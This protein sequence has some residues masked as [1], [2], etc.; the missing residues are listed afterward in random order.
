VTLTVL[1]LFAGIGGFSLGLHQ[2]GLYTTKAFCEWDPVCQKVLK[3]NFPGIPVYGDIDELVKSPTEHCDVDVMVGGFP[4]QD[5]SLLGFGQGL[6]GERS[7][8]WFSFYHLIK[9]HR[10][11]G[12]IIENVS[13]L[14]HR[15]GNNPSE[16]C[17]NR[18]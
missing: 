10:P 16:P 14:V 8:Y 3:K 2:T 4:C 18:V 17:R 7:R 9:T 5:I 1:D 13:A 15:I 6:K 12:V 11:Q